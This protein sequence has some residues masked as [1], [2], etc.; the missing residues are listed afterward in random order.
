MYIVDRFYALLLQIKA[1]TVAGEFVR[2]FALQTSAYC[3]YGLAISPDSAHMVVS[4]GD[5]TLSVYSMPVGNC[6]RT[7]GGLGAGIGQFRFP[8]KLCFNVAGNILVA[9]QDNKRVQEVTLN[10]DH[11]RFIGIGKIGEKIRGIAANAELIVVGKFECIS[12]NRIMMFDAVTG[13]FVRAFGDFGDALGQLMLGC[14]GIRF[15]PDC[16]HIILA[17]SDISGRGRLSVFTLAGQ[18]VRYIG[19]GELKDA[20]DVGFA[21]NGDII[22]CDGYSNHH[23][24]V[25]SADGG[26]LLRQWGGY[27]DADWEFEYPTA[28]AMCGGQLYVLDGSSSRVQVFE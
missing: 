19:K 24:C 25:Y 22:V 4:D 15:T 9:E 23:V 17:E 7:F 3:N 5:H 14:Y 6:I 10:G 27:G 11:V 26:T 18:F 16:Q 2:K 13:A 8:V 12:S 1:A 21:D 28:L 20:R